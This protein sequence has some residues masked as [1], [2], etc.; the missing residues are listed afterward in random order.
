MKKT[1][2]FFF[3]KAISFQ[4]ELASQGGLAPKVIQIPV[5]QPGGSAIS[6][7]RRQKHQQL[8]QLRSHL[9]P[10]PVAV[11]LAAAQALPGGISIRCVQD[12]MA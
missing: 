4:A 2:G 3:K 5:Q 12:L 8:Q 1:G 9:M 6:V 7:Q 10:K 11:S